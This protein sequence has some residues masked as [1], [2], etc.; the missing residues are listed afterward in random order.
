LIGLTVRA[1]EG[2]TRLMSSFYPIFLNDT[3]CVRSSSRITL[4][5][6]CFSWSNRSWCRMNQLRQ[7]GVQSTLPKA[8]A[9]SC[10]CF[11]RTGLT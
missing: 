5:A 6:F 9:I 3:S 4:G 1:V 10:F 11:W 2:W 7:V 8:T